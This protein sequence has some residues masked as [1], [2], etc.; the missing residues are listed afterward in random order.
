MFVRCLHFLGESLL[1]SFCNSI[2]Y[3]Y[4]SQ[5][6]LS[7]AAGKYSKFAKLSQIVIFVVASRNFVLERSETLKYNGC[8]V[9]EFLRF[10]SRCRTFY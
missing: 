6:D 10:F 5:I 9:S 1:L 2:F 8:K 7:T 3:R 4:T